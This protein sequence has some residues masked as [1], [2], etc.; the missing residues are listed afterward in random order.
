MKTWSAESLVDS[1]GQTHC[2]RVAAI[3][4]L[5]EVCA[6]PVPPLVRERT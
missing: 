4:L 1:P 5:G 2:T 6:L 3:S